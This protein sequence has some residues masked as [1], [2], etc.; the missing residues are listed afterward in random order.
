MQRYCQAEWKNGHKT[1]LSMRIIIF[2]G[3]TEGNEAALK[4]SG[5]GHEVTVSVATETGARAMQEYFA[6]QKGLETGDGSYDRIRTVTGR[7][8][9]SELKSLV[10]PFDICVD[11]T[12]PF[13]ERITGNL[14][15]VCDQTGVEYIR[16]LRKKTEP[17]SE[18]IKADRAESP[19][20]AAE[21]IKS[22][23]LNENGNVLLTTGSKELERYVGSVD[24]G[25]LFARVLP[26][27]ESIEACLRAGIPQRNIIAA[28]GPFS[29]E[30]NLA[31]MNR[32]DIGM[33]VTKESGKE[34][35]FYDKAE[36]AR[37][38][39][40]RLVIIKRPSEEGVL[41][42]ELPGIISDISDRR[43][44][45]VGDVAGT[46]PFTATKAVSINV[47]A[48]MENELK[49]TENSGVKVYLIGFGTGDGRQLTGE[50]LESLRASGLIL[51]PGRLLSEAA[52][53]LEE[54]G[55]DPRTDN[56]V[57]HTRESSDGIF[58][59]PRRLTEVK[60]YTKDALD[61]ITEHVH[62][63]NKAPVSVLYGGDC[64]F[65]SGAPVLSKLLSEN[66]IVHEL[67][68]GISSLQYFAARL[69]ESRQE[70]RLL[71]AHGRRID[72][73]KEICGGK[74]VF[75]LTGGL[76]G[77]KRILEEL[78]EAGLSQLIAAIG[79]RLSY[80]DELV[81]KDS[82]ARVY[83]RL[84]AREAS[85]SGGGT[86]GDRSPEERLIV[87]L[88]YPDRAYDHRGPGIPD[89]SFIRGERPMTKQ[90][91]RALIMSRL[92]VREM[93][94]VLDIGAGTGAVS[95]EFSMAAGAVYAI[96]RDEEGI[97]LI[98]KNRKRFGAWNLRV[99]K[100]EAPEA[101]NRLPEGLPVSKVFIGGSG[102]R[103]ADIIKH[104]NRHYPGAEL[105]LTAVL[106]E[107]LSESMNLLE[108]LGYDTEADQISVSH[109]E[110]AGLRHMLRPETPVFLI[111]A[112]PKSRNF[113]SKPL[114]A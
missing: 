82:A 77:A 80:P 83:E 91:V 94:V 60:T 109:F 36:A 18:G 61:I 33:L 9:L 39:G 100:G 70:W 85:G 71:S 28:W 25:R 66:G 38:R 7:K 45:G 93:D 47:G 27:A 102:G 32:F 11:A 41:F 10:E 78:M 19:E 74:P 59:G 98:N 106:L 67:V 105:C 96:E 92:G 107:T 23:I 113:A 24:K 35:G 90:A 42:E 58:R 3:T 40:C 21:Y 8:E 34:G 75:L 108:G 16:L 4:L 79:M 6:G 20:E 111:R 69:K 50:A 49:M 88:I 89:E 1:G 14:K 73:L 62:N 64:T 97:R 26:A 5:M 37:I 57:I 30:L 81:Y 22:Y 52:G 51:G 46:L 87:L 15:E 103:L 110:K 95:I 112:V 12:H 84:C 54:A 43:L 56:N 55:D 29:Q 17:L 104:I 101:L 72:I 13:A 99:L 53:L 44:R 31:L 48:A 2:G 76:S 86:L 68:P 114:K 63:G 65:Y